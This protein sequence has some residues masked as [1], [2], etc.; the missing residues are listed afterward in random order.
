MGGLK[1]AN[2]S[3]IKISEESISDYAYNLRIGE[4]CL[5]NTHTQKQTAQ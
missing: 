5:F 2:I 1:R 3:S 4:K